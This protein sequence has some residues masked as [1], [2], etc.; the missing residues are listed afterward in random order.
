MVSYNH[1]LFK[2]KSFPCL[3]V[4]CFDHIP[5][6]LPFLIPPPTPP[7]PFPSPNVPLPFKSPLLPPHMRENVP[8]SE[9]DLRGI[10]KWSSVPWIFYRGHN[11]TLL[12][13]S[14]QLHCVYMPH[15][16]YLLIHWWHLSWFCSVS[17]V[18]IIAMSMDMQVSLWYADLDSGYIPKSGIAGQCDSSN[19]VLRTLHAE[20]HSVWANSHSY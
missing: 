10:T 19:F 2:K 15:F 12:Y 5:P 1:L 9:K 17:V 6:L 4:T 7:F 3:F 16:L 13:G 14:I 8:H 11:F 20:F 18:N